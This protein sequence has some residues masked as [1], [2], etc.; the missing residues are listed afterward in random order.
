MRK[1]PSIEQF[2]HVVDD[3]RHQATYIGQSAA[4]EP[5]Y[6][7]S[8]PKPVLTFRGLTKLHGSNCGVRF[9]PHGAGYAWQAQSRER[10]LS[11]AEDNFGFCAWGE[12]PAGSAA[13]HIL[14]SLCGFFAARAHSAELQAVTVFGEWCG[15]GVNGK[16]GIGRLPMRWVIF[17]AVAEYADES[18]RWLSVEQLAEGWKVKVGTG[19]Q[20]DLAQGRLTPLYF[21]TDYKGWEIAIDFNDPAAALAQL[22]AL[23]LDVEA[24]CPVA[25]AMGGEG[26][27]EGIVW[28]C[29]DARYGRLTFKTKGDK[30]KGTKSEKLVSVAPEVLASRMAFV[31]AVLTESRLEQGYDV[32]RATQKAVRLEQLGAFL[33]WIGQ[34]V[35]KE[36]SD[37]LTASGLDRKDVM[38]PLNQKAKTWF[39]AKV[40]VF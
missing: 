28:T 17:G 19:Y 24:A 10:V 35:L 32:L 37:T 9:M 16:T 14:G 23:T 1:F 12:S 4:D 25:Q 27:G 2:R 38:G 40:A 7:E 8:L 33:K 31:E 21:I 20:T 39:M 13:L 36:E 6:D 15:P 26:I 11:V 5:L 3:V 18:E 34:D 29:V 30:H 22:E